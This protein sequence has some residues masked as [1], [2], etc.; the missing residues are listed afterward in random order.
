MTITGRQIREARALLGLHRSTLAA[1]VRSVTTATIMRAELV[2]DE[3]P[4]TTA[5][6]TAIQQVLERAGVEFTS[7]PPSVRLREVEP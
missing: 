5:Q 1:R 6:G 4:I 3:P 2:D 7:D